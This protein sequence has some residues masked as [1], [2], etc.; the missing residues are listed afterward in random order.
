MLMVVIQ[1]AGVDFPTSVLLAAA[2]SAIGTTPSSLK[3]A[4]R[5]SPSNTATASMASGESTWLLQQYED[6]VPFS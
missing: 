3:D 6:A 2:S 4:L 1:A 5:L